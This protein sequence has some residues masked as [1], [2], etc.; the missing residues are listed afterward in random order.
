MCLR[1]QTEFRL[2]L[3][4]SPKPKLQAGMLSLYLALENLSCM[5]DHALVTEGFLSFTSMVTCWGFRVC[6]DSCSLVEGNNG[7]LSLPENS[8]APD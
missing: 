2:K 3:N 1:S 8:S 4:L 6:L 5:P 7:S